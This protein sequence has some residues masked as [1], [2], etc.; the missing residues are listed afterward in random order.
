MTLPCKHLNH[1]PNAFP[2]LELKTENDIT[3]WYRKNEKHNKRVQFCKIKRFRINE[4]L[5]CYEPGYC[6]EYEVK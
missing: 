1:N 4:F 6:N 3:F 5:D 2:L